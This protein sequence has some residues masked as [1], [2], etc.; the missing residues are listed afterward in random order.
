MYRKLL[1]EKARQLDNET[2][3]VREQLAEMTRTANEHRD[4]IVKKAEEID[5][6]TKQF[7]VLNAKHDNACIEILTYKGQLR[8]ALQT[9][10]VGFRY[11]VD[12]LLSL[13]Y[14]PDY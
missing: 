12:F 8:E 13:T 11:L 5:T 2:R 6:L 14:F 10:G 9:K 3:H 4:T 7:E 1:K